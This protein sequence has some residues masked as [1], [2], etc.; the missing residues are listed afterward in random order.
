MAGSIRASD[1]NGAANMRQRG[2][3]GGWARGGHPGHPAP[4][5]GAGAR[6]G[7][8]CSV[9]SRSARFGALILAD[10]SACGDR[11]ALYRAFRSDGRR[12]G[13]A[14][15]AAKPHLLARHR[16][17]RPRHAFASHLWRADFARSSAWARALLGVF[18]GA[19]SESSSGY[20]GGWARYRH[21][22]RHGCDCSRFR[23]CCWRSP[24][25]PCSG[26]HP[27]CDPGARRCRSSRAPPASHAPARCRW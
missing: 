3:G 4:A 18:V 20:L 27:Q 17:V 24:W 19:P 8:I 12:R 9:A 23:C 1:C 11:R 21:A 15:S 5:R 10:R 26:R 14:V 25:P 13:G 2:A 16:C 7:T 22:A 6:A